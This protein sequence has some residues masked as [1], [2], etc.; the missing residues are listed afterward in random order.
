MVSVIIIKN[1]LKCNMIVN[2]VNRKTKR[3]GRSKFSLELHNFHL[4]S[5]AIYM[6][7]GIDGYT[8]IERPFNLFLCWI[9]TNEYLLEREKL[10]IP[11]V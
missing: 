1:W 11:I 2:G 8:T 4:P 3:C 9:P 7:D 10:P 5:N 6:I